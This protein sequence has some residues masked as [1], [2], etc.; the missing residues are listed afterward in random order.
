[1]GRAGLGLL[2]LNLINGKSF[3][4]IV[5]PCGRARRKPPRAIFVPGGSFFWL[6]LV[7]RAG[8]GLLWASFVRGKSFFGHT[9]WAAPGSGC[10][11]RVSF[12]VKA[13]LVIPRGPRRAGRHW[14]C[15]F[16]GNLEAGLIIFWWN[17]LSNAFGTKANISKVICKKIVFGIHQILVHK[18]NQSISEFAFFWSQFFSKK[19]FFGIRFQFPP[20]GRMP[21]DI[22][23]I[24][25][26]ILHMEISANQIHIFELCT[27]LQ[28]WNC[29][30]FLFT[31]HN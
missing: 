14:S 7:G 11:G 1:M 6:R 15:R 22:L 21:L 28:G 26:L 30:V 5:T 13:F 10:F 20:L 16:S 9:S 24:W 23:W 19:R 17:T 27:M 25:V 18:N 2:W 12:E 8:H 29:V 31:A 4:L 3:F